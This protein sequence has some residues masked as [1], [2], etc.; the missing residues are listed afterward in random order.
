MLCCRLEKKPISQNVS[1]CSPPPPLL[2]NLN[3]QPLCSR[4]CWWL[5]LRLH[6]WRWKP[7]RLLNLPTLWHQEG[8]HQSS[9]LRHS[10]LPLFLCRESPSVSAREVGALPQ[11]TSNQS[12]RGLAILAGSPVKPC[13]IIKCSPDYL[14][15]TKCSTGPNVALCIC[16]GPKVPQWPNIA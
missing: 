7:T 3:P 12:Q 11:S 16:T 5:H 9:C 1:S 10:I 14:H 4:V 15:G 13:Q 2:G 8:E 6:L